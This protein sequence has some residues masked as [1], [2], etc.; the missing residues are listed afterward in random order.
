MHNFSWALLASAILCLIIKGDFDGEKFRGNLEYVVKEKPCVRLFSNHGDIGCRTPSKDGTIG[1]L[2]EISSLHDLESIN[3]LGID[4]VALITGIFFNDTMLNEISKSG[5]LKG[6]IV[7]DEESSW[8]SS[9]LGMYSV[10]VL[11]PQ[12]DNTDQNQFSINPSYNWNTYGNGLM[13]ESFRL[14]YY[15]FS[16]FLLLPSE[17][18]PF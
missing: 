1:A 17:I 12:G 18:F 9:S 13:H 2:Y 4:F 14:S 3:V 5:T 16:F 6:I 15:L 11:S 10:D 7:I 8:A